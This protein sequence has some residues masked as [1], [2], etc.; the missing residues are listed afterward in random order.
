MTL[1]RIGN[2]MISLERINSVF[3]R[4]N[5]LCIYHGAGEL[6]SFYE[7]DAHALWQ[8]LKVHSLDITP[9]ETPATTS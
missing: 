2:K 9:A 5:E 6:T 8:Y 1:I 4:D 3:W 7:D